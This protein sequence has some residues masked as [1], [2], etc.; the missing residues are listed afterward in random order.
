VCV[1]EFGNLK[2]SL[3]FPAVGR[4][5]SL[6]SVLAEL[7]KLRLDPSLRPLRARGL[8]VTTV[9][10]LYLFWDVVT[11]VLSGVLFFFVWGYY[12]PI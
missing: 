8:V 10:K 2:T 6:N 12:C 7:S 9:C 11:R 1:I 4:S 3:C 5:R